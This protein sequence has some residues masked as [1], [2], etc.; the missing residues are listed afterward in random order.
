MPL[1]GEAGSSNLHAALP[2]GHV[3]LHETQTPDQQQATGLRGR[4]AIAGV[5]TVDAVSQWLPN[6]EH[7]SD[8][9][10]KVGRNY[11]PPNLPWPMPED[12]FI[13]QSSPRSVNLTALVV[14]L[15]QLHGQDPTPALKG[16][17]STTA[18][19]K[20]EVRAMVIKEMFS[21]VGKCGNLFQ[22]KS[23]LEQIGMLAR[24]LPAVDQ[25]QLFR[26]ELAAAVE[27]DH[28]EKKNTAAAAKARLGRAPAL[29][30]KLEQEIGA[31]SPQDGEDHAFAMARLIPFLPLA[32]QPRAADRCRALADSLPDEARAPFE[33]A[34]SVEAAPRQVCFPGLF[35][36]LEREIATL[37]PERREAHAVV[38]PTLIFSLALPNPVQATCRCLALTGALPEESR[39]A[40]IEAVH[41][42]SPSS[43][44]DSSASSL[45]G[46]FLAAADQVPIHR[47]TPELAWVLLFNMDFT[48]EAGGSVDEGDFRKVMNICRDAQPWDRLLDDDAVFLSAINALPSG[49]AKLRARQDVRGALTDAPIEIRMA[50]LDMLF[51]TL[52][53]HADDER[54]FRN[55]FSANIGMLRAVTPRE[56]GFDDD[57]PHVQHMLVSVLQGA[58]YSL[59]VLDAAAFQN[60]SMA[61]EQPE[62][63]RGAVLASDL[64]Q[65]YGAITERPSESLR[66][67]LDVEVERLLS[68]NYRPPA[69]AAAGFPA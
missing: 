68:P 66:E 64:H 34:V 37:P 58:E 27:V 33:Q 11:A 52:P 50:A 69:Y 10:R 21:L 16:L 45:L 63:L 17:I 35:D 19:Q 40:F 55:D 46:A 60:I 15:A 9:P 59:N 26:A 20:P 67:E 12:P 57:A 54:D 49:D 62:V 42:N 2:D 22:K 8:T 41:Q 7:F 47:R 39:V 65:M 4:E 51:S 24:R 13:G 3:R 5:R 23:A 48:A 38:M 28:A 29:F 18:A 14:R 61:M 56:A 31:L 36:K 32:D 6:M 53:T 1:S 44:F 30:D 25:A 43:P